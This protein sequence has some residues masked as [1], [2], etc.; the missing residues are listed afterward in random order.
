MFILLLIPYL[1][2]A[3]SNFINIG[4]TYEGQLNFK[5]DNSLGHSYYFEISE[6]LDNADI[7]IIVSQQTPQGDPNIFLSLLNPEPYSI[8]QSELGY[9]LSQGSD[10]CVI[11]KKDIQIDKHYYIGIT[12]FEDC[13]YTLKVNYDL[14]QK[15]SMSN[16]IF[17]YLDDLLR[18]K[19]NEGSSS[20][21]VKIQ[22]DHTLNIE[23]LEITGAIIN[24]F[25]IENP[26]HMYLNVGDTLPS[27]Q[28][29]D[30]VGKDF[31][32]GLKYLILPWVEINNSSILTIIV[33]SQIGSLIE[34]KTKTNE[35]IRKR[36]YDILISG[37]VDLNS[38]H[39]YQIEKKQNGQ[40]ITQNYLSIQLK[41]Y[42]G[43][44]TVYFN[45]KQELPLS[46][47]D[48]EYKYKINQTSIIQFSDLDLKNYM[49]IK[50]IDIIIFGNEL[51]SYQFIVIP[52]N[53]IEH[54]K[55]NIY[56]QGRVYKDQFLQVSFDLRSDLM[57]GKF[58]L[59]M[60]SENNDVV[61]IIKKSRIQDEKIPEIDIKNKDQLESEDPSK[62]FIFTKKD[63]QSLSFQPDFSIQAFNV[64]IGLYTLGI[65][66]NESERNFSSYSFI[67]RSELKFK[68]LKD[69]TPYKS[70]VT[71]ESYSYFQYVLNPIENFEEMQIM[72]ISIQ[73]SYVLLSSTKDYPNK[74]NYEQIGDN[75]VII[76]RLQETLKN[77]QVYFISVYCQ[78]AG[79]FTI[80]VVIKIANNQK[81]LGTY[82]WEYTQIFEGDSQF[83]VL[84]NDNNQTVGLF[85]ID[86]TQ[87]LDIRL[88][89]INSFNKKKQ[90]ISIH[91][92]S[93]LGG[94]VM[95]GFV[96]PSSNKN[97]SIWTDP[98]EIQV[99]LQQLN[100]EQAVFLRIELQEHYN[101]STYK[102]AIHS[103]FQ[104]Q[105][106]VQEIIENE[107]YFGYIEQMGQLLL[108]RYNQVQDYSI[109]KNT[110]D[111]GN[112][113]RVSVI[114]K[115]ETLTTYE[116]TLLIPK[117]KLKEERCKKEDLELNYCF[118]YIQISTKKSGFYTLI[119]SHENNEISLHM[120]QVIYHKLPK[121]SDHY[122]SLIDE[123]D[124]N[125]IVKNLNQN[126]QLQILV[127]IFQAQANQLYPYPQ[128][129]TESNLFKVSKNFNGFH[130]SQVSIF[131]DEVAKQ[132]N[133]S[134]RCMIAITI[135]QVPHFNYT[136]NSNSVYSIIYSSGSRQLSL[137]SFLP[138][139]ISKGYTA[140]YRVQITD[141][142]TELI[143]L[144]QEN[145]LCDATIIISKDEFPNEEKHDWVYRHLYQKN[146]TIS[147]FNNMY[148]SLKGIYYIGVF[149]ESEC[150]YFI[151]YYLEDSKQPQDYF[152]DTNQLIPFQLKQNQK[153]LVTSSND[154]IWT[155]SC[156]TVG[157]LLIQMQYLTQNVTIKGY[158]R[159]E[160][161][162][163]I[164]TPLVILF[165]NSLQLIGYFPVQ[166]VGIYT[167]QTLIENQTMHINYEVKYQ[168][169]AELIGEDSILPDFSNFTK[170]QITEII[171][172]DDEHI[173]HA[174]PLRIDLM[175]SSYQVEQIKYQ[176]LFVDS[177]SD[178]SVYFLDTYDINDQ[179]KQR[180][181][182]QAID[183]RTTQ[184]SSKRQLD[185][186][187]SLMSQG[188]DYINT[189]YSIHAI[190][191]GIIKFS[192]CYSVQSRKD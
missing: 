35:R 131:K 188:I 61:I 114:L 139:K 162:N 101:Y 156:K 170:N 166:K 82:P 121:E 163:S 154:T 132:F 79:I 144:L 106:Q 36:S 143:I 29:S 91:I 95:H 41:P 142:D 30:Y 89:S 84:N 58:S 27:S 94:I 60:E 14:E 109:I 105:R 37:E 77:P 26:F 67:L 113:I 149:G 8:E 92:L 128:V 15:M 117:E 111:K 86:L 159:P 10:L 129:E 99:Y 55:Q 64:N 72:L 116:S 32:N 187:V 73:G 120:D 171:T 76:Y 47:E 46:F 25:E 75:D 102:I 172:E 98:I 38:F 108:F 66:L 85:K 100:G 11:D 124:S 134:N 104:S 68:R 161:V 137:K 160:Q 155:F 23:E 164:Y 34:L 127:I 5:T 146:I 192:Y 186:Y 122:Y 56:Y 3:K 69:N 1:I 70:V 78:T 185:S 179:A 24:Y 21:I 118:F 90:L 65:Y 147:K 177:N 173:I 110:E 174:D 157:R 87:Q 2:N 28:Q 180:S 175:N 169:K 39:H 126:V 81:Q 62:L 125:I 123:R 151:T 83:H 7:I 133:S 93:P 182:K 141:E 49:Q 112:S 53:K 115:N 189:T 6:L 135:R 18:F 130:T 4:K 119:I 167:I 181:Q 153:Q 22:I 148:E 33:E 13:K 152:K 40:E 48:Y 136:I 54:I 88:N 19:M 150:E 97:G 176:L 63:K 71:K 16:S 103:M 51:S 190:G 165:Q 140:Y 168:I 12:C 43:L 183:T 96:S 178:K 80:T 191:K 17:N 158:D 74:T 45:F 138:G 145:N 184:I 20:Q 57:S 9:C 31:L 42:S 44:I 50:S 59:Q 52:Q 107:H